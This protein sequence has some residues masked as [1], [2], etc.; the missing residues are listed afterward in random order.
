VVVSF[1]PAILYWLV[2][3][4]FVG[5]WRRLGPFRTYAILIPC[6]VL[7]GAA[8]FRVRD[9]LIGTDLDFRWPLLVAGLVAYGIAVAIEI[10]CRRA[11]K[12]TTL[13]GVPELRGGGEAGELLTGGIYGRVR[14]PRYVSVMFGYAAV[15]LFVNYTGLYVMGPLIV[16]SLYVVSVLEDREL[17]A[18]FGGAHEAYRA[19][20]PR[21]IPHLK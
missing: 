20:V 14:H 9:A 17:T 3:H 7:V 2:V 1:P 8:L 16:V 10:R 15:A 19:R 6:M 18:R 4:P 11:L 12:F 21:F 13:V 5:F